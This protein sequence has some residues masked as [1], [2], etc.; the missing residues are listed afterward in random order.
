VLKAL[1]NIDKDAQRQE[2]CEVREIIDDY[3]QLKNTMR[4]RK[5]MN[6]KIGIKR[7]IA[8]IKRR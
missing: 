4:Q 8:L 7:K 3:E 2:S 5:L 1:V 6:T